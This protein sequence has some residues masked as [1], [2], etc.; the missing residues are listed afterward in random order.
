MKGFFKMLLA[1]VLGVF[2]AMFLVWIISIVMFIGILSGIGGGAKSVYVPSDNTILKLELDG[3]IGDRESSNFMMG[4][5]G[6]SE[7]LTTLRDITHAI[8]QAKEND[9]IRGIYIKCGSLSTGTSTLVSIRKALADFKESGKF[10][11]SY[12]DYYSQGCYY[13]SSVADKVVMNP[14]GMLMWHGMS[15]TLQFSKGL[16]DKIGLRF[17]VFKVGTFKSAVEPYVETKMSDAN[18]KQTASFMND[19]WSHLLDGISASRNISVDNLNLYADEYMDY[20]APEKTVEYGL[21]DTLMY[22]Q[23]MKAYLNKLAGIEDGKDI[24]LASVENINSLPAGKKKL[25]KDKIAV[26]YAEGIITNE[27]SKGVYSMMGNVITDEEYVKHLTKLKD[28]K[29]VKAVVLRVNSPGGS[30]YASEQIWRAMTELKKEKPVI[31]SMGD[32]AASGGYY[33]SCAA[34]RI[35]AEPTTI[36]G[37]IG[38]FGLIPEGEKLHEKLG[39]TFDGVATNKHSAMG[40][41]SQIPLLSSAIKPFNADEQKLIQAYVERTYDLFISHCAD[42]RSKTKA[43]IDAIGQGRVWT[44]NQAVQNGLVDELGSLDDAVKIAAEQ[45]Q[46]DDYNVESFPVEKDPFMQMIEEMMGG[47]VKAGLIRTFLGADAYMQYMIANNKTLPVD[48]LQ[49]IMPEEIR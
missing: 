13:L 37:S 45:A 33:I 7:K 8:K 21:V 25:S 2:I 15:S 18:R 1:S 19:I 28:N 39:L 48:I 17:Q 5:L 20:S 3:A 36:T 31:V 41:S 10:I 14:Q 11:V 44:G 30:A 29:N 46:L 43:E 23:N 47:N 6:G 4:I 40:A 49:A 38:V 12:G 24:K 35:I 16:Y 22:A 42:G 32:V 26:L 27:K 34:D 9:Q